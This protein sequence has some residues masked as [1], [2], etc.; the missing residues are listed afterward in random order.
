VLGSVPLGYLSPIQTSH[1]VSPNKKPN[2]PQAQKPFL[3]TKNALHNKHFQL[4]LERKWKFCETLFC[5]ESA[6]WFCFSDMLLWLSHSFSY[7]QIVTAHST[8]SDIWG[9]VKME[10]FF[11]EIFT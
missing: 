4:P 7:V 5:C 2:P 1:S 9:Y 10:T 8:V 11:D 3:P 6:K